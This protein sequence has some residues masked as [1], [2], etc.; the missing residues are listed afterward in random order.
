MTTL[1]QPSPEVYLNPDKMVKAA[2]ILKAV[3]HPIRLSVVQELSN[4]QSISVNELCT[5]LGA[6]QSLLSH[7]LSHMKAAGLVA[8]QRQGKNIYYSLKELQLIKLL[9]CISGCKC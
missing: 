2:N 3:S 9:D 1:T 6:E 4:G 5:K 8:T 7:H